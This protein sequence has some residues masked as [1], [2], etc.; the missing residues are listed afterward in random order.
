[1]YYSDRD[2]ERIITASAVDGA[3]TL[4]TLLLGKDARVMLCKTGYI[5]FDGDHIGAQRRKCCANASA[6]VKDSTGIEPCD[7]EKSETIVA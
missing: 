2:I 3:R 6:V 7:Q 4:L 5:K 1:M